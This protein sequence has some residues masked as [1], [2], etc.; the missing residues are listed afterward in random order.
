MN[1]KELKEFL[2]KNLKVEINQSYM[3]RTEV[4]LL[5]GDE[6]ISED[7]SSKYGSGECGVM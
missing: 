4:K 2:K 6:V 1:E 3:G 5:L 7:S